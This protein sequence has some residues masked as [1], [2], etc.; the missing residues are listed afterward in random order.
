MEK[1]TTARATEIMGVS[2]TT[3]L[4][5]IR[6]RIIKAVEG[7]SAKGRPSFTIQNS[8]EELLAIKAK[9]YDASQAG[10]KR[11][12]SPTKPIPI[13]DLWKPEDVA[14]EAGTSSETVQRW[15][16]TNRPKARMFIHKRAFFIP[17]AEAEECIAFYR[18]KRTPKPDTAAPKPDTAIKDC[19]ERIDELEKRCAGLLKRIEYLAQRNVA[20]SESSADLLKRLEAIAHHVETRANETTEYAGNCVKALSDRVDRLYR[21]LGVTD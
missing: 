21:D 15:M 19:A 4:K 17:R 18:A 20:H 5:L 8:P 10:N 6:D 13:K 3:V 9:H 14:K 11:K 16:K 7:T 1:M 2:K 12:P